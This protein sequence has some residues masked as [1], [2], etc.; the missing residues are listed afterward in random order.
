MMIDVDHF[1]DVNDSYGHPVGDLVL[2]KIGELLLANVRHGD[3]ACRYG[4]EEFVILLNRG[5]TTEA[6]NLAERIRR[7]IEAYAFTIDDIPPFHKT[8]SIG[9]TCCPRHFCTAD[10]MIKGADSALYKAKDL[11]RNQVVIYSADKD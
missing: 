7:R 1:K 4:G 11:G 9:L 10:K 2:A 8:I 3:I 6:G 5:N